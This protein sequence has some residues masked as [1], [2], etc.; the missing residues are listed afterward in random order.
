MEEALGRSRRGA[1]EDCLCVR[2]APVFSPLTTLTTC[3]W[4]GVTSSFPLVRFTSDEDRSRRA[5][6][7]E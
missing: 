6:T 3:L 1:G 2:F 7:K 5:D 4:R